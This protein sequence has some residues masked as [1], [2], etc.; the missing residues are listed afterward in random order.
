MA[1]QMVIVKKIEFIIRTWKNKFFEVYHALTPF[2]YF[3]I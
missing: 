1:I 2:N 3:N